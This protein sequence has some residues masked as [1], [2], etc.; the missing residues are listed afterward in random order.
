MNNRVSVWYIMFFSVSQCILIVAPNLSAYLLVFLANYVL[1][2]AWLSIKTIAT[3]PMTLWTISVESEG[4]WW[5]PWLLILSLKVRRTVG[6]PLS[7]MD[8]RQYRHAEIMF[9]RG[10]VVQSFLHFCYISHLCGQLFSS[11]SCLFGYTVKIVIHRIII[12]FRYFLQTV[13]DVPFI[14]PLEKWFPVSE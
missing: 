4:R 13:F 10:H 11:I 14:V 9:F 7:F 3:T 5:L 6:A 2:W 12:L 8:G 1:C